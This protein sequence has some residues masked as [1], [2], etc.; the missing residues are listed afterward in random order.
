M[1]SHLFIYYLCTGSHNDSRLLPTK[2]CSD[3]VMFGYRA[4]M[5]LA[6]VLGKVICF[7]WCRYDLSSEKSGEEHLSLYIIKH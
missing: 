2:I 4:T 6:Q 1:H 7:S 3:S 5:I